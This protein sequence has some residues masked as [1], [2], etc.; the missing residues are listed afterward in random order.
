M[1]YFPTQRHCSTMIPRKSYVHKFWETKGEI[2]KNIL[3]YLR[4]S[5]YKEN[6]LS[7]IDDGAN[8]LIINHFSLYVALTRQL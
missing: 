2:L 1:H 7:H 4:V 6:N 3:K 8:Q 5:Q